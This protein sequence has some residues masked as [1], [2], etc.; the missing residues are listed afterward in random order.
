M[1]SL[2]FPASYRNAAS[3]DPKL[4]QRRIRCFDSSLRCA[5][6]CCVRVRHGLRMRRC[7]DRSPILRSIPR[8]GCQVTRV[9]LD[10]T[11]F[12]CWG[13]CMGFDRAPGIFDIRADKT[14]VPRRPGEGGLTD[15]SRLDRRVDSSLQKT[16]ACQDVAVQDMM[17]LPKGSRQFSAD[18]VTIP[19]RTP[20]GERVQ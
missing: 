13:K 9:I 20:S 19:C 16:G 1:P 17:A 11:R 3:C 12:G 15:F 14:S 2:R 6:H 4:I 8:P 7:R 10:A 5:L 18:A